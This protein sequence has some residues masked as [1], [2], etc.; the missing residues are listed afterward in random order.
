MTRKKNAGARIL[1]ARTPMTI[2]HIAGLLKWSAE[3]VAS[4]GPIPFA[5]SR[6][7]R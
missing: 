3:L 6:R 7:R 1:S 2:T 5:F 4:G